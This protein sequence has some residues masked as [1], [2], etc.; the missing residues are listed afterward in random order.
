MEA[1]L[2]VGYHLGLSTNSTNT[3]PA[4]SHLHCFHNLEKCSPFLRQIAPSYHNFY[5]SHGQHSK[6]FFFFLRQLITRADKKVLR[7][8]VLACS[9]LHKEHIGGRY[10][11]TQI[12]K[13]HKKLK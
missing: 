13:K 7:I 6:S 3:Q 9:D 11:D 2:R 10:F 12:P 8:M 4:P 1:Y 5:V